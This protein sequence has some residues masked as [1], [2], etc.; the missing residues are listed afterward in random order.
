MGSYMSTVTGISL[1]A[2]GNGAVS[3]WAYHIY[4]QSINDVE[5]SYVNNILLTGEFTP[6]T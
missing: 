4:K 2:L 6:L 5:L 3:S 1:L